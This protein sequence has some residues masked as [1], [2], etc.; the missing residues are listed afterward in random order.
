VPSGQVRRSLAGVTDL[1]DELDGRSAEEV[2]AFLRTADDDAVRAAV[3]G[4]GTARVL[5]LVFDGWAVRVGV[6]PGR[7]PGLLLFEVDDDGSP[8]RHALALTEGGARHLAE[9]QEKIRAT[10]RTSLV[11]FLKVAAGAQDPKRLVVTGRMR[12]SGDLV[13]A[14]ATLAGMQQA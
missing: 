6:R 3:H 11:R 4:I 13:W 5:D 14:V 7:Q 2:L 10:V 1:P 8:H 12:L 9:P